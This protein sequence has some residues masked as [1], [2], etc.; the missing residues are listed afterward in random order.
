MKTMIL[1]LLAIMLSAC[2]GDEWSSSPIL[3]RSSI[4]AVAGTLLTGELVIEGG[5]R[6]L[7]PHTQVDV[8]DRTGT[9]VT[10]WSREPQGDFRLA[11][12]RLVYK[13]G[14]FLP[15]NFTGETM[16]EVLY[17]PVLQGTPR[18]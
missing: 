1:V 8:Y 14:D 6:S 10:T 12:N 3:D 16:N 9:W 7:V 11:T 4:R 5:E 13:V 15:A 18:R 2:G 17:L